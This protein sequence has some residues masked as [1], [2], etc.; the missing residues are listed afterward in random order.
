M[1]HVVCRQFGPPER[2]V[3]EPAP[4]PLARPGEVVIAV[5]AAGVTFVDAL[6]VQGRYQI[7]PPLPFTPGGEVAGVIVAE[8]EGVS[9]SRLQERVL[10]S[11]GIGGFADRLAVPAAMARRRRATP[12]LRR[13]AAVM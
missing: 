8:G 4:D 6:L 10:V 7:K 5:H 2:L 11:C 13:G 12:A 9:P 1:R 3:V